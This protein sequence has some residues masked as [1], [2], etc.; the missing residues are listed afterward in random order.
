MVVHELMEGLHEAQKAL[1]EARENEAEIGS[2]TA[3]SYAYLGVEYEVGDDVLAITIT[4]GNTAF[5]GNRAEVRYGF[6]E[7]WVI[8]WR[9]F[10]VGIVTGEDFMPE[11]LRVWLLEHTRLE[12]AEDCEEQEDS[13]PYD[14]NEHYWDTYPW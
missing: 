12:D 14:Y 10:D 11:G 4:T 7:G 13:E 8:R 6:L 1:E 5:S 3:I 2:I 9:R